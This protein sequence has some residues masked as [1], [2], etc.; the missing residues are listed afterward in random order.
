[1][2]L[3]IVRLSSGV[4]TYVYGSGIDRPVA[5]IN[6]AGTAETCY[7]YHTDALGSVVA[8]SNDSGSLV[9]T[10]E[11]SPFG[12]QSVYNAFGVYSGDVSGVGNPYMFTARRFDAES[13]L[14]YYRARMYSAWHGR[15]LQT[16]PLGYIDSMNLYAYCGNNP[17]NFVDP[18]GL[19]E[20]EGVGVWQGICNFFK[21]FVS[22]GSSAVTPGSSMVGIAQATPDSLS[23]VLSEAKR[24]AR[25][26]W[27]ADSEPDE[28]AYAPTYY[29]Y[30]PTSKQKYKVRPEYQDVV[31]EK[32]K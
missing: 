24:R 22:V 23:I 29:I 17:V 3:A 20:E 9:E 30:D 28:Q 19:C 31:A 21:A 12:L 1:M 25:Q 11:C 27:A 4:T 26:N 7:Y 2:S 16:D 18:M 6:V 8:L 32:E 14:Y 15:F 5:M 13:G 10:Y